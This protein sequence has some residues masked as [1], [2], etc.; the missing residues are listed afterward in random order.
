MDQIEIIE[1]A[2]RARSC[3]DPAVLEDA[4][5]LRHRVFAESLRWVAPHPKGIETDGYDAHAHHFVVENNAKVVGYL[6][7]LCGGL[8][9]ALMLENEFRLLNPQS[10]TI[11]EIGNLEI[12]R[13][14]TDPT[15]NASTKASV[16]MLL[17][18]TAYLWSV[19]K[20]IDLWHVVVTGDYLKNL[21]WLG[22]PF[23][24]VFSST[25]F[26]TV[27]ETIYA[28]LSLADAKVSVETQNPE[29]A[30]WFLNGT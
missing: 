16:S 12:T 27:S 11:N 22:F 3:S 15:L 23:K 5:K 29:L 13:I 10:N 25:E 2:L 20:N 8:G 6:R 4:F 14:C 18:K 7:I 21:V 9:V 19:R 30:Q 17:Y 28:T 1:G 24:T 26:D